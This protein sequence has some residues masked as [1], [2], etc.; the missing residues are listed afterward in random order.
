MKTGKMGINVSALVRDMLVVRGWDYETA[1][2]FS[3]ELDEQLNREAG[4]I[5]LY[6][7]TTFTRTYDPKNGK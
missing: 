6:D 1:L 5:E 3:E 4:W 2:A 7:G